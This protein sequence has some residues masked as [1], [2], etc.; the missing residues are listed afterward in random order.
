MVLVSYTELLF[1]TDF[2]VQYVVPYQV[3]RNNISPAHQEVR[4]IS[5]V[6]GSYLA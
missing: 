4:D 1:T 2:A 3:Y 6:L 5:H